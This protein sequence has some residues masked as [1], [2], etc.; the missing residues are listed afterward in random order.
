MYLCVS[1]GV[2]YYYAFK[3]KITQLSKPS[4]SKIL[5]MNQR[6]LLKINQFILLFIPLFIHENVL[7][8]A[9]THIKPIFFNKKKDNICLI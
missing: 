7:I 3:K 1:H 4:G 2:M 9:I 5:S 6:I 8:N